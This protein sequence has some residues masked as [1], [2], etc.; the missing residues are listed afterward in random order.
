MRIHRLISIFVVLG[1]LALATTMTS[2]K[3]PLGVVS[4]TV[5]AQKV[6]NPNPGEVSTADTQSDGLSTVVASDTSSQTDTDLYL[7]ADEVERRAAEEQADSSKTDA[8]LAA[9]FPVSFKDVKIPIQ[10]GIDHVVAGVGT[11][12]SGN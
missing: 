7:D 8:A 4:D 1:L 10:G 6:I 12:N 9:R 11:R 3:I 2:I 5:S